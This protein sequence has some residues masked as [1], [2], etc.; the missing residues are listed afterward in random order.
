MEF[1][2]RIKAI[3][4]KNGVSPAQLAAYLNKS[5]SAVRAW[6]IERSKPDADTL[7]KLAKYFD[8]TTDYLLGLDNY[9]NNKEKSDI[10]AISGAL[11][12][13]ISKIPDGK[14]LFEDLMCFLGFTDMKDYEK[15][16]HTFLKAAQLFLL[17]FTEMQEICDKF[18]QSKTFDLSLYVD[19][20]TNMSTASAGANRLMHIISTVPIFSLLQQTEG[21]GSEIDKEI[22]WKIYR[23]YYE[24]FIYDI[25]A[26][27]PYKVNL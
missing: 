20:V 14:D 26:I 17:H 15:A 7:I 18:I 13:T 12:E 1:K 21:C 10:A 5:E 25:P 23:A 11:N 3:R 16:T 27:N 19:I 22:A 9:R 4:M 2:D 6:E 8:C 24:R